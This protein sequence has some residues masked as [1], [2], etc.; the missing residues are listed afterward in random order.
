LGRATSTKVF[1]SGIMLPED[2]DLGIKPEDV[3]YIDIFAHANGRRDCATRVNRRFPL[4]H[5]WQTSFTL[6]ILDPAITENLLT[7]MIEI[8]GTF[9]GVGRYRPEKRGTNGRFRLVS[10]KYNAVRQFA[11]AA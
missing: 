3:D 10:M 9:K 6:Y 1:E 5:D 11:T 7:E 4:I 2:L 8:A